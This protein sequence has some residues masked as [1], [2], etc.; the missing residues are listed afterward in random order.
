MARCSGG[1]SYRFRMGE[2]T[3]LMILAGD[4]LDAMIRGYSMPKNGRQA[5][6]WFS[7]VQSR[8]STRLGSRRPPRR[9]GNRRSLRRV[10][11]NAA[12]RAW[13]RRSRLRMPDGVQSRG[14]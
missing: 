8:T 10:E 5:S 1:R 9:K 11:P 6:H 7:H 3:Y 14:C 2:A 13:D 12:G 4:M